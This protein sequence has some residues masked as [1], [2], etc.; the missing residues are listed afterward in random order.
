LQQAAS[1]EMKIVDI[2]TISR[3]SRL[4]L[5]TALSASTFEVEEIEK[6]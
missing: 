3:G 1:K 4:T 2:A 5:A 6:V